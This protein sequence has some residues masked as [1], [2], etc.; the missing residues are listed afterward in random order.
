MQS[1]FR[2]TLAYW[3]HKLSKVGSIQAYVEYMQSSFQYTEAYST[4]KGVRLGI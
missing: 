3:M 1:I 4:P 2:Y